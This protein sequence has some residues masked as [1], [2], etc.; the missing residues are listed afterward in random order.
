MF[1]LDSKRFRGVWEQRKTE[2]W[3]F[4]S[5]LP[6]RTKSLAMQAST[7]FVSW[8]LPMHELYNLK[9]SESSIAWLHE[10]A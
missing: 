3:D 8:S 10:H 5:L 1:S 2:E 9:E 4:P 7:S 6:N